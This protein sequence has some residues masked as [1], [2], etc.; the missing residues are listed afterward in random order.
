MYICLHIRKQKCHSNLYAFSC[1]QITRYWLPAIRNQLGE[2]HTVPVVLV[3]NKVDLH[4]YSTLDSIV[5]IMNQY[6]E[7]ETCVECSAKSLKNISELFYYAQKAVLHPTSPLYSS[8]SKYVCEF[9]YR[10]HFVFI[11]N[12]PSN[13]KIVNLNL[14]FFFRTQLTDKCQKALG[15]I[16]KLCDEDNDG[17]LNDQ[18]LNRFQLRCFNSPLQD[19]ALEDVKN[20]VKRSLPD[21]VF[22]DGLTLSGFQFLHTLFI[23]RGRDE[24]T[25]TV[26]RKFGYNDGVELD[27]DY[28]HP[29][30]EIPEGC[31]VELSTLGVQFLT[32]LFHKYDLDKDSALSPNELQN[33][34]SLCPYIPE[35]F[36]NDSIQNY[37]GPEDNNYI[38]L[39]AF[40]SLWTLS[41][42]V[43]PKLTLEF[44]AYLG[45]IKPPEEHQLTAIHGR[46]IKAFSLLTFNF[47]ECSFAFFVS[48]QSPVTNELTFKR[49]RP[50]E[51]CLRVT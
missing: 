15:R 33:L 8:E 39:N 32:Q 36:S 1:I 29:G 25:W 5:P 23:Q 35:L 27:D 7:I 43:N 19:A 44:L 51:M 46:Q 2:E 24:T 16:F 40:I 30:F 45:Y 48:F 18:E 21:G 6:S 31:T 10:T 12:C 4:E 50:V 28:L 34:F 11:Q 26:L 17:I 47:N 13:V 49:S 37:I 14:P 41:T 20:I 22:D 38:K 9:F 3:G 42:L